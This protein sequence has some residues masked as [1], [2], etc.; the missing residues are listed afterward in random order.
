MSRRVDTRK[1]SQS[2]IGER[3]E[4]L[5]NQ[6]SGG[7]VR[8][9][10]REWGVTR[11]TLIRLIDGVVKSPRNR[12]FENIA[13]ACGASLGWLLRG[14]GQAPIP[15]PPTL[16]SATPALARWESVVGSL[17]LSEDCHTSLLA[18]PRTIRLAYNALVIEGLSLSDLSAGGHELR[19][20]A[21]ELELRAWY[22]LL[23]GLINENGGDAV[24]RKLESESLVTMQ[25]SP[26]AMSL[27]I[28]PS[29]KPK[30]AADL[31]AWKEAMQVAAQGWRYP[32]HLKGQRQEPPLGASPKIG[33]KLPRDKARE[34]RKRRRGDE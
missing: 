26:V 12:A 27:F 20:K 21:E 11:P 25:F 17:R 30:S 1:S 22:T 2:L 32:P 5:V 6:F 9:A 7:S 28:H 3:I 4:W 29:T 23:E 16:P 18:V 8:A 24:R 10:S 19:A 33:S 15:P 13:N 14:E 31:E 34:S